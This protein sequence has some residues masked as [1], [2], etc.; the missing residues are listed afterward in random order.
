MVMSSLSASLAAAALAAG[1]VAASP[2]DAAAAYT[3]TVGST[4][5]Y[6]HPTDTP[7]GAFIDKDGTFYFQQSAALYGADGPREWEFY[8]GADFDSATK[9]SALSN[10]VNPAESRDKNND[11]TWRCN[12]SPTGKEATDPCGRVELRGEELLRPGRHLGRP[13]HRCLVRPGA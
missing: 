6:A 2:A 12:M 10:A 1:L 4:G 5:T 8:T 3:V 9:S 11:T 13:G 7:A